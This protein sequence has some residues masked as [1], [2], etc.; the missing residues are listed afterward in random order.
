[1]RFKVSI[2]EGSKTYI[3]YVETKNL[4]DCISFLNIISS[5]EI[6]K[7]VEFKKFKTSKNI[8]D[9][10]ATHPYVRFTVINKNG[11][12]KPIH[13]YN[14]IQGKLDEIANHLFEN[15]LVNDKPIERVINT[16]TIDPKGV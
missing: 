4:Q 5:A 3:E 8:D 9:P 10:N 12:G 2:K 11:E 6:T 14:V 16:L 1:M 13:L 7:I 15:M